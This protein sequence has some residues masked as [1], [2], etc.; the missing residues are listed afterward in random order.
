MSAFAIFEN[1]EYLLNSSLPTVNLNIQLHSNSL[2]QILLARSALIP[3]KTTTPNRRPLPHHHA[4]PSIGTEARKL[5]RYQR[6]QQHRA[7]RN[8]AQLVDKVAD[9]EAATRIWR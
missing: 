4:R 2:P 5:A 7:N 1:P 9:R 6:R 3:N 8:T